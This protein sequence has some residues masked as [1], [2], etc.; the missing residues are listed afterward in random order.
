MSTHQWT[1][2]PSP[3][4]PPHRQ[5]QQH[6]H[7]YHSAQPHAASAFKP[8]SIRQIVGLCIL[9]RIGLIRFRFRLFRP[10]TPD[11]YFI[12]FP[13]PTP[14]LETS[15]RALF[16]YL[17]PF[18]L[19]MRAYRLRIGSPSPSDTECQEKQMQSI[20]RHFQHLTMKVDELALGYR[21]TR[22]RNLS[23]PDLMKSSQFH[24][25]RNMKAV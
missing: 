8:V 7:D 5:H 2:P 9:E 18:Y 11:L 23:V 3:P 1:S 15:S 19:S 20:F 22:R 24:N 4:S 17:H 13:A 10:N 21:Y 14:F 12:Y 25:V 16:P 6:Q